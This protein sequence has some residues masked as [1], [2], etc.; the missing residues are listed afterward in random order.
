ME[1]ANKVHQPPQQAP[2]DE[3]VP[4]PLGWL[5]TKTESESFIDHGYCSLGS[6]P[7]KPLTPTNFD[8]F[9]HG[10]I[11]FGNNQRIRPEFICIVS[12]GVR[13][14]IAQYTLMSTKDMAQLESGGDTPLFF[15]IPRLSLSL[16]PQFCDLAAMSVKLDEIPGETL[17]HVVKYL[18]HHKGKEPDPL[19]CPVR[20]IHMSQICSD[21]WDATFIDPLSKQEIFEIILAANHLDIKSLVHLGSAKIA[22]LIKQLDQKEIN[23]IIEEEEEY[24]RERAQSQEDAGD[25]YEDDDH[26][27]DESP[28]DLEDAVDLDEMFETADDDQDS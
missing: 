9:I 17:H 12:T 3:C 6:D 22:T 19:P 23:R 7:I 14:L 10:F 27:S 1:S 16:S 28:D 13:C 26:D 18:G 24:R 2:V 21:Q 15:L 8:L 20:S 11:G 5:I 25:D 4:L